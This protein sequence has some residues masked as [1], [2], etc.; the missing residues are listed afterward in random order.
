LAN[1]ADLLNATNEPPNLVCFVGCSKQV[2]GFSLRAEMQITLG[3]IVSRAG[4]GVLPAHRF[5]AGK[6]AKARLDSDGRASNEKKFYSSKPREWLLNLL[7]RSSR[8][9]ATKK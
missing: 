9:F 1:P 6:K 2:H 3:G 7:Y 8:Q 4:Q 5:F